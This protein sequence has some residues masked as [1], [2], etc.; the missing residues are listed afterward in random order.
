MSDPFIEKSIREVAVVFDCSPSDLSPSDT[1]ETIKKW[2]SLNHLRLIMHLETV[3]GEE[4]DTE[5]AMT[6]FTIEAIAE[7]FQRHA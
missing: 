2:D 4:I 3:L 7:L 1:I 5:E 6:L